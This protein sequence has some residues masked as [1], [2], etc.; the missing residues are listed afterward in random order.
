MKIKLELLRNTMRLIHLQAYHKKKFKQEQQALRQQRMQQ[1][2]GSHGPKPT[3]EDRE[4]LRKQQQEIA[5]AAWVKHEEAALGNF[6][7]IY[8]DE[9]PQR[10]AAYE[11]TLAGSVQLFG[12]SATN[13]RTAAQQAAK[14]PDTK[15][16][17]PPVKKLQTA[18]SAASAASA[19]AKDAA[20][21]ASTS[22]ASSTAEGSSCNGSSEDGAT[23][24][25]AAAAGSQSGQVPPP[26]A[27]AIAAAIA[28]ADDKAAAAIAA[29]ACFL[30]MPSD[31]TEGA[32]GGAGTEVSACGLTGGYPANGSLPGCA[33]CAAA[34]PT[35]AAPPSHDGSIGSSGGANDARNPFLRLMSPLMSAMTCTTES[36]EDSRGARPAP[37]A[38]APAGAPGGHIGAVGVGC[39]MESMC[40]YGYG[41]HW[42]CP[43]IHEVSAISRRQPAGPEDSANSQP[44]VGVASSPV[45]ASAGGAAAGAARLELLARMEQLEARRKTSNHVGNGCGVGAGV[46][47]STAAGAAPPAS[48][49]GGTAR[50]HGI[51]EGG[52]CRMSPGLHRA[53]NSA[54][55]GSAQAALT[56]GT[57]L[58]ANGN[59]PAGVGGI[60]ASAVPSGNGGA[61]GSSSAGLDAQRALV[62]HVAIGS[63]DASQSSPS[64]RRGSALH[65]PAGGGQGGMQRSLPAGSA[66][67][68]ARSV[69]NEQRLSCSAGPTDTRVRCDGSPMWQSGGVGVARGDGSTRR[70]T[71][72]GWHGASSGPPDE[73]LGAAAG[74]P[75]DA[76]GDGWRVS[77]CWGFFSSGTGSAP[78]ARVRHTSSPQS[79][80]WWVSRRQL[81]QLSGPPERRRCTPPT[82]SFSLVPGVGAV[83]AD[84]GALGRE[85]SMPPAKQHDTAPLQAT[86]LQGARLHSLPMRARTQGR[87]N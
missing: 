60:G 50:A 75:A 25:G 48:A 52:E 5:Q 61:P 20:S 49:C 83:G 33:Q 11:R 31:G 46:G 3:I 9:D 51:A 63:Q 37:G 34:A 24:T 6:E 71:G 39:A 76:D 45:G 36:H 81:N 69:A 65:G 80:P 10:A 26:T 55:T 59:A 85:R 12:R 17:A 35:S 77:G 58:A 54:P 82:G 70:T 64:S 23:P 74:A 2:R 13:R 30:G 8:P 15:K 32:A 84:G 29:A 21:H 53:N 38:S 44:H 14:V 22:S 66:A 68:A 18:A 78:G 42:R 86:S 79:D 87:G 16:P 72:Q 73:A 1:L 28:N 7:R 57:V 47:A 27:A 41:L 43:S 19:L 62:S 4:R 56:T 40:T 67:G